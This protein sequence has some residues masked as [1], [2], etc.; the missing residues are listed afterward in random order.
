MRLH[1]VECGLIDKRW[2]LDG[3]YLADRLQLLVLAALVELVVADI[4][5][6]VQDAVNLSDPPASAVA[7]EDA[8]GVEMAGD[9]LDPH[10]ATGAVTFQGQ[11]IDEPHRIGVQRVDLQLLLDLGPA[12]LGRD[13]PVTDRRQRTIPEALPR[14]LLQGPHHVLGILLGLVFVKQRHDLAH[15][16]VHGIVAHLL[17]DGDQLDAVPGQ[18]ADA[19]LKLEMIAEEAAERMDH[20]HVERR[21][22]T[23]AGLDHAL[24]FGPAVVGGGGTRLDIG[25]DQPA[26][27]RGA[28]AL[29]LP[30]L[31]RDRDIVLGLSRGR[32]AQVQG[33]AQRYGHDG[34]S[35]LRSPARSEEFIEQIAEPC[36]EH[37]HLGVRD[38]NA[39]GP[40]IRDLRVR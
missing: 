38:R 11:P 4:G 29:T 14:V 9:V 24:E 37:I 36:L 31:I 32:D 34:C 6:P 10:R 21:G 30:A 33:G 15:H 1:R 2:D 5:R 26:A 18:L 20:Y 13:H 39:L 35:L 27:A 40:I 25:L 3:D 7:R 16:D 17:G 8:P 28:V 23:D 19:E 22:L 12:L